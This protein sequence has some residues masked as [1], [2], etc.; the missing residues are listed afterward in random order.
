M[1]AVDPLAKFHRATTNGTPADYDPA[2][3][4]DESLQSLGLTNIR[5]AKPSPVA[6]RKPNLITV[7]ELLKRT[8]EP[9]R[10]KVPNLLEESDRLILTGLEGKGKSTLLRQMGMQLG[11]GIHPFGGESF[12]PLRILICDLENSERQIRRKLPQLRD[13]AGRGDLVQFEFRPDGIRINTNE[14]AWWLEEVITE[15]YPDIVIIGPVYKMAGGNPKDE[16][17][18]RAVSEVLDR[19]RVEHKFALLMEAHTP[20]AEGTKGKRPIRPY[21]ASL[22][23]RWPE[24][25]IFI[26]ED[27]KF[28]HWRGGR[29]ERPWPAKLMRGK[30]WPWEVDLDGIAQ[31]SQVKDEA[32]ESELRGHI[33]DFLKS[34]SPDS[35]TTNQLGAALK[36]AG[37]G[38]R[39]TAVS[40]AA[41][42]LA[43]DGDIILRRHGQANNFQWVP[44]LLLIDQDDD[45]DPSP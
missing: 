25:G 18:A 13:S 40:A 39:P 20:Y 24:F 2:L 42:A 26:H 12:E 35:K 14:D 37:H 3:E 34:V 22:W 41:L 8:D 43:N 28:E 31:G 9:Y 30:T 36:A 16:E 45:R 17:A 10:W 4:H 11:A 1:T 32:S 27:G 29:E 15:A 5:P 33:Y 38:A 23:S 44:S 19:L 7:D 21:G 6:T